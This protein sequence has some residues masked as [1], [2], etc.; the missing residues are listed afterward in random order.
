MV[1][2][3]A[4]ITVGGG[5]QR[6]GRHMLL[7]CGISTLLQLSL[8]RQH[9]VQSYTKDI[10]Q[11]NQQG[12]IHESEY[13]TSHQFHMSRLIQCFNTVNIS[14]HPFWIRFCH[15]RVSASI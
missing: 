2:E 10:I 13:L 11:N 12:N 1:N 9:L 6:E 15:K 3:Y 8:S 14:T 5:E 7:F 4:G